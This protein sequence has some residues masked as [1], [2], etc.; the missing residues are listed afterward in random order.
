MYDKINVLVTSFAVLTLRT[1]LKAEKWYSWRMTS[2]VDISSLD[3]H[4]SSRVTILE[5]VSEMCQD[6]FILPLFGDVSTLPLTGV[7]MRE[8]KRKSRKL[9]LLISRAFSNASRQGGKCDP[10]GL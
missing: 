9:Q 1:I 4:Q 10:I 7:R 6:V 3:Q 5:L 8:V 2:R